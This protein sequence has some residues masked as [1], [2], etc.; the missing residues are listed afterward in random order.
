MLKIFFVLMLSFLMVG[1]SSSGDD[2]SRAKARFLPEIGEIKTTILHSHPTFHSKWGISPSR[3][4]RFAVSVEVSE[5]QGLDNLENV[6][7]TEVT[8][9]FSWS[10]FGGKVSIPLD[11]CYK[12]AFGTFECVFYSSTRL[13]TIL[14]KDWEL[15][16]E[17]VN[18]NSQTKAFKFRLPGGDLPS[19]EEPVGLPSP[20]RFVYS[21]EYGGSSIGGIAGLEAMT[22]DD[23]NLLFTSNLGTQT[24][25]V[26]FETTD[27]RAAYYELAFYDQPSINGD[28]PEYVGSAP[29]DS[30]SISSTPI[31]LGL[32]VELDL[33][34]FEIDFEDG[35]DATDVD[36]LH[37]KLLDAPSAGGSLNGFTH[38]SYSEFVTL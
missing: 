29:F 10:F 11:E 32:P 31:A 12:A 18:G 15:V 9:G 16:A 2:A 6:Y 8:D 21:A 38:V 23:N 19:D 25:R 4:I 5:P 3:N 13:D 27:N 36:G 1:C 37:I 24:F 34:W 20:D 14:L 28:P 17:D 26:E 7:V 22:V 35:Y 33:N 30:L